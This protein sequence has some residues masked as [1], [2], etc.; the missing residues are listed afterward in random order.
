VVRPSCPGNPERSCC[1][2]RRAVVSPRLGGLLVAA[3]VVF[4]IVAPGLQ[5]A[6]AADLMLNV[7]VVAGADAGKSYC[8]HCT[9]GSKK[10]AVTF[11]SSTNDMV[12][13]FA[14]QLDAVAAKQPKGSTAAS[15][16]FVGDAGKDEARLK[17]IAKSRNL[18]HVSL[19]VPTKPADL[20]AWKLDAKKPTNAYALD[21][22]KIAAHFTAGCPHCEGV[23]ATLAKHLGGASGTGAH[24]D[25]ADAA[26]PAA[27][28]C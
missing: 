1:T 27:G 4:G 23:A 11:V 3:F 13:D 16:V 8:L 17:A 19:A 2:V 24:Q 21:K 7:K 10:L 15:I 6:D 22:G 14:K 28:S 12:A 18:K 20:D 5:H 26:A 9:T 25:H